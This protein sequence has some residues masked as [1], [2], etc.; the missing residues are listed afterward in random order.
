[1]KLTERLFLAM[2]TTLAIVGIS[3]IHENLEQSVV[4]YLLQSDEQPQLTVA[5]E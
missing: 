2:F 1:M 4:N 3:I 5:A